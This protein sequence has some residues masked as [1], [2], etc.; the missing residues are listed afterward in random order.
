MQTSH[1]A[2][3]IEGEGKQ[4]SS[5]DRGVVRSCRRRAVCGIGDTVAAFFPVFIGKTG[6]SVFRNQFW[7]EFG[8]NG[9]N[10]FVY[11]FNHLTCSTKNSIM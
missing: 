9:I 7:G 8:E 2:V 3:Q 5:V 10:K 11:F 1:N 4:T 6:R